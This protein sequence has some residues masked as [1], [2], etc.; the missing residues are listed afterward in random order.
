MENKTPLAEIRQNLGYS[1]RAMAECCGL[2]LTAYC[3]A[4]RAGGIN[5]TNLK[6]LLVRLRDMGNPLS[7]DE[8]LFPFGLPPPKKLTRRKAR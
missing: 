6:E 1:L 3:R 7:A 8:I 5:R 2:S 4:E